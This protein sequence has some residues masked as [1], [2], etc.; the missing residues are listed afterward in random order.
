MKH[1][2]VKPG[3]PKMGKPRRNPTKP[4]PIKPPTPDRK[5][6]TALSQKLYEKIDLLNTLSAAISQSP[7]LTASLEATLER[8]LK[9]TEAD[10]GS[11]HLLDP[12]TQDLVL[13]SS[14][15][16]TQS[17]IYNELRIPM[18][19]CLC[20]LAARIGEVVISDDLS[21]DDRLSRSACRDE[22]FGSMISVPLKAREKTMGI[23]T[24]YSRRSHAFSHANRQLL[25]AISHHVGAA[26]ENSQLYSKTKESAL[27]EERWLISQELHDNVAQSLAYLNMQTKLLEDRLQSELKNP[28]LEELHQI[29]QVI[30][31]TYEDVRNMLIDFRTQINEDESLEPVLKKYCEDFSARTG[32]RAEFVGDDPLPPLESSVR[33]QVFRMI[34]ESLSNVRKHARAGKVTVTV[35]GADSGIRI[36]VC[37]NGNGFDPHAANDSAQQ[38]VGLSIM[39][40]RAAHLNGTVRISTAPGRGTVVEIDIPLSRPKD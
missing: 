25:I 37:D 40:E 9:I 5:I 32:I 19:A 28:A 16:V 29:R 4:S 30:Q 7:R 23:L 34:Q 8:L 1:R 33:T 36:A 18:G 24:L 15:G 6:G 22:R 13:S 20:G 14:R 10:I 35:H 31:D 27:M 3:Q 39:K 12:A 17:F 2:L 38:H 21:K 11:I 26:I